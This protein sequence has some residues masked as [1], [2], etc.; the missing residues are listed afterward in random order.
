MTTAVANRLW[1]DKE[2]AARLDIEPQTLAVWRSLR[3]YDLP[4]IK[5][6]RSV[7]YDPADVEAF[8]ARRRVQVGESTVETS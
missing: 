1:T 7:K 5:I 3:R 8:I 2:T 6:G 4:F